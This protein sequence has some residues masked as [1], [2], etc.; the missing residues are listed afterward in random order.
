MKDRKSKVVI[1]LANAGYVITASILFIVAIWIVVASVIKLGMEISDG[2]FT[3]YN[4]LD[5]VALVV[6]AFAVIDVSKYLICEEVLRVEH[7][8]NPT[9]SRKALTK[10]V[11][12]IFTAL[13]L[14]GLV[15]TIEMAKTNIQMMIYP[16]LLIFVT[17][18]YLGGLGF[19]QWLS[20]KS[21][22]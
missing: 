13:S 3:V 1:A 2:E 16:A 20:S 19:Y 8:R 22:K 11:L 10:L 9:Q 15:L 17:T 6:F 18:L 14:E 5:E 21:E 12:I 4:L 7:E